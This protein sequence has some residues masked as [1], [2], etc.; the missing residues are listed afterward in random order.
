VLTAGVS[1]GLPPVVV[2]GTKTARGRVSVIVSNNHFTNF[3]GPVT[4]SVA[5]APTG[6]SPSAASDVAE[7]TPLLTTTKTLKLKPHA[8]KVVKL[9]LAV[10]ASVPEGDKA[11]QVSV[12]T[13]D[14]RTDTIAGQAFRVVPPVVQ[15]VGSPATVPAGLLTFGKAARLRVPLRNDGNVQTTRTPVTYQLL[16]SSSATDATTPLFSTTATGKLAIKPGATKQVPVRVTIPAGAFAAGNY[17]LHVRV[18]AALN[19][20]NGESVVVMPFSIS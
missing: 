7:M 17:F 12:T 3:A 10:P 5:A 13:S 2:A 6:V 16:V 4:I 14:G 20:T 11:L 8:Q 19:A 18:D 9:K 1:G 15:L